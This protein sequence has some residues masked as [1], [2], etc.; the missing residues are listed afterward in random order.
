MQI[1]GCSPSIQEQ[2]SVQRGA[3]SIARLSSF[4]RTEQR[5]I[6]TR[7]VFQPDS[8]LGVI[9]LAG[10]LVASGGL[11]AAQNATATATIRDGIITSVVIAN[12]GGGYLSEPIVRFIGGGGSGAVGI[13]HLSTS[14]TVANIEIVRGGTGY[15]NAPEVAIEGPPSSV[16]LNASLAVRLTTSGLPP[17]R[18]VR[19]LRSSSSDGS[20][21]EWTN[22]VVG[23]D[24]FV[25]VVL[26]SEAPLRFYRAIETGMPGFI[27]VKPGTFLMGTPGDATSDVQHQVTITKGFWICEHEVTQG[28]YIELMGTNP[29]VFRG[30]P[31]LPVDSVTWKEAATYCE[32]LTARERAA[33][34]I[35]QREAYRLPSE[36]EWEYSARGGRTEELPGVLRDIAW[37][38]ANS[39]GQTWPVKR[40]LPNPWG[41]YDV[42]GNVAEWCSDWWDNYPGDSEV[43]PGGPVQGTAKV[44]RGG[45]FDSFWNSSPYRVSFRDGA[46]PDARLSRDSSY[47][48]F[49]VVLG[50]SK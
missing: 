38:S 47:F 42:I 41:L 10:I 27:W 25:S 15:T 40:K 7:Q 2:R 5:T 9:L 43:D 22:A 48:G 8:F 6:P 29:S 35:S 19:I 23:A 21:S 3:D 39:L 32:K 34:R 49:R 20:F 44:V 13:A 31:D 33:R 30:D 36:A 17:G 12:G 11:V 28:E 45:A 24:G 26:T 14:N 1:T 46:D 50:S 16:Q 4:L 18:T 37:T